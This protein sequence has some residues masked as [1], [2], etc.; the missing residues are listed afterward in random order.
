[1]QHNK[2]FPRTVTILSCVGL[3]LTGCAMTEQSTGLGALGGGALGAII[4]EK[5]DDNPWVGAAVGAGLG[6]LVGYI[7]HENTRK[8]RTAQQTAK[9]YGYQPSQGFKMELKDVTINPRTAAPGDKV[10]TTF[11]YAVLGA[12]QNG[13]NVQE[14]CLLRQNDKVLAA[15]SEKTHQRTD[16]T[17]RGVLEFQ[18]PPE[19]AAGEY[20]ISREISAQGLSDSARTDFNVRSDVASLSIIRDTSPRLS[21]TAPR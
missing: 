20:V 8:S 17:W 3:V 14:S 10:T 18:V 9:D 21:L 7:I 11:E 12:G 4:G 2:K 16:G 5:V 15:L 13:V 6:A 1:M 19:A